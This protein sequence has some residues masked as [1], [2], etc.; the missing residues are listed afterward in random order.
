MCNSIRDFWD[1]LQGYN[2]VPSSVYP[3][4]RYR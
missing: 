3:H 1:L 4:P 2:S